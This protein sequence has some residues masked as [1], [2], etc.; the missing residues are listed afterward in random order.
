[1]HGIRAVLIESTQSRW[2]SQ[3]RESARENVV[4]PRPSPLFCSTASELFTKPVDPSARRPTPLYLDQL[5]VIFKRIWA[6]PVEAKLLNLA[7]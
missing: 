3:L 7:D 5:Q 4:S 2:A 1:M 6:S